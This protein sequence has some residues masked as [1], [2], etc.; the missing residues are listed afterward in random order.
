MALVDWQEM[1][2]YHRPGAVMNKPYRESPD[3]QPANTPAIPTG[4]I[5]SFG[6]FGPK[7]Q[8]G[9]AVRQLEN[10]DWMVGIKIIDSGES[11]EYRLTH[12]IDDP[13]AA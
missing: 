4:T 13:E 8:V 10:G 1:V 9:T 7:Y 2:E 12:L 5:K 11:A 6:P 3:M